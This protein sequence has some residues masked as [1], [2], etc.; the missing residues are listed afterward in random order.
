[1]TRLVQVRDAL[2]RSQNIPVPR[3]RD[4]FRDHQAA[5]DEVERRHEQQALLG[6]K[7]VQ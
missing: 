1:M 5:L 7:R 3:T 4:W 2:G 6:R